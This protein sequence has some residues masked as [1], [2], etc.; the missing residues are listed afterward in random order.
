[1]TQLTIF[2][3][4]AGEIAKKTIDHTAWEADAPHDILKIWIKKADDSW[5]E[6]SGWGAYYFKDIDGK[7]AWGGIN[8][9][10]QVE[11][12]GTQKLMK[13]EDIFARNIAP[14]FLKYGLEVSR[15]V[16]NDVDNRSP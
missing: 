1:M 7:P 14:A 13:V 8:A 12:F 15:T 6:F 5:V 2:Y 4:D 3:I 9:I 11:D 10:N 16:W